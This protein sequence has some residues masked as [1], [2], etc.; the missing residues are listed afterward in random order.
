MSKSLKNKTVWITGAS[1]GIGESLAHECARLGANVVLSG[2]RANLLEAVRVACDRADDH[3][4]LP[5]DVTR[6]QTH[7]DSFQKIIA[8]YGA[9]DILINNSGITQRSV[10]AETPLDVE[11]R[12]MEVNYFGVL[13]LTKTVLPHMIDRDHGRIVVVS[14]VM[15]K[16]STPGHTTYSASKHALHGYFEGLRAELHGTGVGIT[17]ICPGYVRTNI[18]HH[19]LLA[20]GGEHGKM[21]AIHENAMSPDVCARSIARAVM[22]GKAEAHVGGIETRAI[23]LNRLFP[24]LYRYLLPRV[25]RE[26]E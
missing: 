25:Y 26:S 14:S 11:R 20:N 5:L 1:S 2:R 13:S 3:M 6:E 23:L 9:L 17:M 24:G 19:A 22:N 16:V 12:I 18:S 7:G 15:G 10:V 8:R 4:T 21:D